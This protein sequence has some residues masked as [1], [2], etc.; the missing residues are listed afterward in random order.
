M[1][2]DTTR[3]VFPSAENDRETYSSSCALTQV[4]LAFLYV[5]LI[6]FLPFFCLST[7]YDFSLVIT[8]VYTAAMIDHVCQVIMGQISA[9]K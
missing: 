4:Q 3:S 9:D 1:V 2:W 6:F 7:K 5:A 8:D